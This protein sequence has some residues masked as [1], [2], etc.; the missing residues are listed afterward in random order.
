VAPSSRRKAF[1]ILVTYLYLHKQK[2]KSYY[3][4]I[5]HILRN[6][7]LDAQAKKKFYILYKHTSKSRLSYP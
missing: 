1:A 6:K 3:N 7:V 5:P 2:F 4:K